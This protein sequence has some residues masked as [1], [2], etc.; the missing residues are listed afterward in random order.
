MRPIRRSSGGVEELTD[1]DNVAKVATLKERGTAKHSNFSNRAEVLA[2][3]SPLSRMADEWEAHPELPLS[4]ETRMMLRSPSK[5]L[6][7]TFE[8]ATATKEGDFRKDMVEMNRAQ[9]PQHV[10]LAVPG[11]TA[12]Q[13]QITDTKTSAQNGRKSGL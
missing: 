11:P 12:P 9:T 2:W 5:S 10:A 7:S 3:D 6:V 1:E 4:K 8:V 13:Q